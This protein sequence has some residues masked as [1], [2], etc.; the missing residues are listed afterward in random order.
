MVTTENDKR[1]KLRTHASY[2][3][4]IHEL[5]NGATISKGLKRRYSL[6]ECPLAYFQVTECLSVDC[7]HDILKDSL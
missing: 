4:D 1:V 5:E 6:N 2:I 7:M 3:S